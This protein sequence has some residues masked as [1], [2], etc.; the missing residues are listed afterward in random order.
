MLRW[1]SE[2]GVVIIGLSDALERWVCFRLRMLGIERYFSGLYTWHQEPWFAG[3]APVR[4]SIRHRVHLESNEL[5]PNKA[6]VDRVIQDFQLQ[7]EHT[8]MVGDSLSKDVEAAQL[9]GVIDVWA[10]YGTTSK[11][12]N[13]DTLRQITPWT[14]GTVKNGAGVQRVVQPTHTIVGSRNLC[15]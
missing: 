6:V 14:Q 10:R 9:A 7:R 13:L 1:A 15:L 11:E 4:T 3:K 8:V 5:K 12:S 2:E